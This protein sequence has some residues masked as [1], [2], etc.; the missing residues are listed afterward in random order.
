MKL[1]RI[2]CAFTVL[3]YSFSANAESTIPKVV[4]MSYD[5]A[6]AEVIKAGW[7]PS[8]NLEQ[9]END[10]YAQDF[11]KANGF[12]EVESCTGS[13]I[14]HCA[15]LFTDSTSST[16][17]RLVTVGEG[18]P[19]VDAVQ[20]QRPKP[21]EPVQAARKS[22]TNMIGNYFSKLPENSRKMGELMEISFAK[23]IYFIKKNEPETQEA[24]VSRFCYEQ[25]TE[26]DKTRQGI[27]AVMATSGQS[28]ANN[29]V[30][31]FNKLD[32][33]E[34]QD[35]IAKGN[36]KEAL[37]IDVKVSTRMF[38][39]YGGLSGNRLT[40]TVADA[41]VHAKSV[42]QEEASKSQSSL[43]FNPTR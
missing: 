19:S 13:G 14:L 17:I 18:M 32:A 8:K 35:L 12:T 7:Q 38:A 27:Q 3:A 26:V 30:R 33:L 22:E 23:Y 2:I 43:A 37:L 11:R 6:R 36:L 9:D 15:F 5:A 28:V 10:V 25:M 4:G 42:A 21:A 40:S 1:S 41:C 31:Q 39:G 34:Q 20:I 29:Q 16:Q 24:T